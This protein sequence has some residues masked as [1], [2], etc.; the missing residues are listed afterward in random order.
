VDR[1]RVGLG[2]AAKAV[3]CDG[4]TVGRTVAKGLEGEARVAGGDTAI[5]ARTFTRVAGDGLARRGAVEA[6]GA[7][8]DIRAGDTVEVVGAVKPVEVGDRPGGRDWTTS[9]RGDG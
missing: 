7:V 9:R 5:L 3:N 2:A 8:A 6:G 1:R 4:K